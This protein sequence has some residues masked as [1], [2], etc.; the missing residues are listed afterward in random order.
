MC[1][2]SFMAAEYD[3]LPEA[4]IK[5]VRIF[6]DVNVAWLRRALVEAGVAA[7]EHCEARARAIF[8]AIAGAQLMARSRADISVYDDAIET[9]RAAGLIPGAPEAKSGPISPS[10][11]ERR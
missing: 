5:E 6:S 11:Q 2:G 1:L 3:D 4:V 10:D 9:Y 7:P 8:A